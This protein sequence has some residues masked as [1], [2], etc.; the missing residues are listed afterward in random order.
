MRGRARSS[1]R[2][3]RSRMCP[4]SPSSS[5][6]RRSPSRA[7]STARMS[8]AGPRNRGT[9]LPDLV[10]LVLAA[11]V[12]I[13]DRIGLGGAPAAACRT[14]P[15]RP[16]LPHR[17]ALSEGGR[18]RRFL[19]NRSRA[20]G[21]DRSSRRL[22]PFDGAGL[23][24]FFAARALPGWRRVKEN[25]YE[26]TFAEG[27]RSRGRAHHA[28][29][30]GPLPLPFQEFPA[31]ASA[32]GSLVARFSVSST[33]PRTPARSLRAVPRPAPRPARR[34][35][36]GS[37]RAGRVGPVR[38]RRARGPRPAEFGRRGAHAGGAA[39]RP[40]RAPAAEGTSPAGLTHVFPTPA[41]VAA[42]DVAR[43]GLPRARAAAL[44]AFAGAVADGSF[45][46]AAPRG[47]P[48]SRSASRPCRASVP[49]P[50]MSSRC[51]PSAR[52]TPSPRATSG[53]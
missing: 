24:R 5:A 44:K 16:S 45:V 39:R 23:F 22:A 27:R 20:S 14:P 52:A 29:A 51:A 3:R 40:L 36:A 18:K 34:A 47:L 42:A 31:W 13:A 2:G 37:A 7:P 49:G 25:L 10:A 4:W 43:V 6:S 50:R 32:E 41:A 26:R 19:G 12:P 30:P 46:L 11:Q 33:S 9:P 28:P 15:S 53:S 21:N 8:R 35:T 1:G 38:G 17:E 48:D